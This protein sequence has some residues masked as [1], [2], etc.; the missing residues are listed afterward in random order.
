MLSIS[1]KIKYLLYLLPKSH[2]PYL[3]FVR[4][5]FA[6][7]LANGTKSAVQQFFDDLPRY[8]SI[9]ELNEVEFKK[10]I[11]ASAAERALYENKIEMALYLW[12]FIN[13]KE[14]VLLRVNEALIKIIQGV[15]L[16]TFQKTEL[17]QLA[18]KY[19]K[20]YALETQKTTRLLDIVKFKD[21]IIEQQYSKAI[22]VV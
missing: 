13:D 14:T 6:E 4:A 1:D 9:L 15:A 22:E 19:V 11:V 2:G 17:V 5:Q 20:E 10:E 21:F 18:Q 16:Y 3:G 12:E 8:L 7:L